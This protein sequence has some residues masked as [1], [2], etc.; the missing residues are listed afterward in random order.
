MVLV[1]ASLTCVIWLLQSLR[2]VEM[3]VNRGLTVGDFIYLTI[4]LLPNFLSIILPIALFTVIVFT[5]AKLVTDRELVVMRA[6]GVSQHALAKPAL[7][8]AFI[9]VAAGYG[10]NLYLLP[11]S[12]QT[13]HELRWDMRYN[14]SNVLL[15]EGAFNTLSAGVTVYVRAG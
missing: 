6:A 14:Y 13:F 8:L 11:L 9:V 7:F 2:F 15:K 10:L 5:Y 12:S 3:I 4:L 1:T